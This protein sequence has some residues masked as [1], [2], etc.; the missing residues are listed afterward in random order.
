VN[1]L[2][3]PVGPSAESAHCAADDYIEPACLFSRNKQQFPTRKPAL[4]GANGQRFLFF[5]R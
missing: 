5:L 2:F 1:H 4:D 3:A